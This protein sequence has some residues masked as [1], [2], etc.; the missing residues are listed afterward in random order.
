MSI[1]T[2]ERVLWFEVLVDDSVLV[3]TFDTLNNLGGVEAGPIG[4]DRQCAR[5]FLRSL[6]SLVIFLRLGDNRGLVV[7]R[8]FR[9]L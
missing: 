5:F 3:E 8:G 4:L 6:R 7:F 2:N 9:R 1:R